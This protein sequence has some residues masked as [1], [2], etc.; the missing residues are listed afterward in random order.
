M[1]EDACLNSP[2]KMTSSS[3]LRM[4]NICDINLQQLKT[5]LCLQYGSKDISVIFPILDPNSIPTKDTF[6]GF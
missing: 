5:K 2:N 4:S 1:Q 6:S 3:E